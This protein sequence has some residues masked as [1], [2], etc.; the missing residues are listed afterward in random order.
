[1]AE[2][3]GGTPAGEVREPSPTVDE[4]PP[5]AS[6]AQPQRAASADRLAPGDLI[7]DRYDVISELGRGGMGRVLACHDRKLGREVAL[8]IIRVTA[9]EDGLMRFDLEARS[10]AALHHPNVVAVFDTGVH[11]QLPY[12]S[13]ELLHGQTL[14]Q[15]LD[16]GRIG[17]R[18]AVGI[19]VQIAKGLSA[20]HAQGVV[21]RDLK[22]ENVFLCDD[23]WAKLLD[24]GIVKLLSPDSAPHPLATPNPSL[25]PT[26]GTE[27]GRILGTAGYMSPEQVRGHAIE[28]RADL[29]AL[30]TV[31]Y[32][33]LTGQRA[34]KGATPV[35]TMYAVLHGQPAP[36]PKELPQR[37]RDLIERCLAKLPEGRPASADEVVQALEPLVAP[38]SAGPA[39]LART[40]TSR[41]T[42]RWGGAAL[43]ALLVL[44][45]AVLLA[46]RHPAAQEP[47]RII[48][49]LPFTVRGSEQGAYLAD[50]MVDLLS[51]S[52]AGRSSRTVDPHALLGALDSVPRPIDL[53]RGQ[54]IAKRLGATEFVL[55]TM[56]ESQGDLRIQAALYSSDDLR[57]PRLEAHAAGSTRAIFQIVDELTAQ[58][59]GLSG[60]EVEKGG[61]RESQVK[62]AQ[63]TTENSEALA[64]YLRGESLSRHG[65]DAGAAKAFQQAVALDAGFALAQFRLGVVTAT[66]EPG[67]S[68]DSLQR[69]LAPGTRLPERYQP[70]AR[71]FLAFEEGRFDEAERGFHT[72]LRSHPED[73]W[74][75]LNL[76]EVVFH[77]GPIHGRT[78][79][80]SAKAFE[81]T[82]LLD[83][84]QQGDPLGH[85][86]DLAQ[87][88][89]NRE[90]IA[91]LSSR[92]LAQTVDAEFV[93]LPI[94]WLRA[95]ATGDAV[96][97]KQILERLVSRATTSRDLRMACLRAL[98]AQDVVGCRAIAETGVRGSDSSKRIDGLRLLAAA[99]LMQGRPEAALGELSRARELAPDGRV[100]LE[101]FWVE[102]LDFFP[103]TPAELLA[104][105]ADA[106]AMP[107]PGDPLL[108]ARL[109][110]LIG[111]LLVRANQLDAAEVE[112]TQLEQLP[113]LEGSVTKDLALGLRAQVLNARGRFDEALAALDRQ[114][115]R[116]PLTQSS[117]FPRIS[118]ARLRAAIYT[119]KN[120]L[121]R[122]LP[123]SEIVLFYNQWEPIY[124]APAALDRA[125]LFERSGDR[126]LAIEEYQ[127]FTSAW[128]D[129]EPKLRPTLEDARR[130]LA[131]LRAQVSAV[132]APVA[133]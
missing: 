85:L 38:L 6:S 130:H 43:A 132:R 61:S 133:R 89:N 50:G 21:H 1:M 2:P 36:L 92:F 110:Y 20:A 74:A 32:E 72:Y 98:Y 103:R 121:D 44:A 100:A 8:K 101:A 53:A 88:G 95:W 99:D 40:L 80:E 42:I 37:L 78:A 106:H 93:T 65:S 33:M 115:L 59:R 120:E 69:A 105:L 90:L 77:L 67:L 118:E 23:G 45:A 94:R 26:P 31:L 81:Q 82:L 76:G 35:E 84:N 71:A 18:E 51:M 128:S 12:I 41:R 25:T 125:R 4:R 34:F 10:A 49:V 39:S 123:L 58:L 63:L 60:L 73:V 119:R 30:G 16:K 116:I 19:A 64:A 108:V 104:T 11:A 83:P 48:A 87:L 3:S 68:R 113:P 46:R 17:A 27:A 109:H 111:L 52:L 28:R 29:F 15:R 97:Q 24:F 129:C 91:N 107:V 70:V 124:R 96:E 47:E 14:R 126:D 79:Q 54:E 55:G 117:Q 9:E 62:L 13:S 75:W 102:T 57:A 56:V 66:E 86:L 5:A 114:E 122:A 112:A 127:R 7:D 22:P 131:A